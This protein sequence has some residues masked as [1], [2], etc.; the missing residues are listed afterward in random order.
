ISESTNLASATSYDLSAAVLN[1]SLLQAGEWTQVI[2]DLRAAPSSTRDAVRSFG[3]VSDDLVGV[4][5]TGDLFFDQIMAGPAGPIFSGNTVT[6][7]LLFLDDGGKVIFQYSGI[8]APSLTSPPTSD[9]YEFTTEQSVDSGGTL[10]EI[11][12]SPTI[13]VVSDTEP[14]CND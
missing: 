14:A 8:T 5:V 7:P 11:A 4:S 6:Q 2:V 13:T 1:I 10:T 12:V 3:F 9:S